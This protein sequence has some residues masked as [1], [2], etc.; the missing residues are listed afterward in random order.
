MGQLHTIRD[1][2]SRTCQVTEAECDKI[3]KINQ[4]D[5]FT[6]LIVPLC[7]DAVKALQLLDWKPIKS[8]DEMIGEMVINEISILQESK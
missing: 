8:L 6:G 1:F 3:I 7:E 2:L 5:F 4:N